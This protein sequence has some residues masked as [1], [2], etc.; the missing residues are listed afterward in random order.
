MPELPEVETVRRGLEPYLVG[1]RIVSVELRRPD[2]RFP[3]PPDFAENLTGATVTAAERR[4]KYLLFRLSSG[5][6]WLSHLGMTGSYRFA[7]FV[8]KSASRYYEPTA[9]EKHDHIQ[10]QLSHPDHGEMLLIYNDARRFGFMDLFEDEATSPYLKDLGPEPLSNSFSAQSM[11]QRFRGR[12][13]PM[14]AV[15]LDQ[16]VV[17]GLGNIY[18]SEAL[19]RAHIRP[20]RAA[21]SLVQPDGAA[22]PALDRLAAAVR[23]VLNEAIAAGGSTLRDFRNA[24]GGAGY[25]QHSFSVYDRE[26]EPCPTPGCDGTITRIV[27]SGRS[28]FFCPRC[29]H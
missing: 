18:V 10:L 24:E 1:A 25:F 2:L 17:A 3:L 4:A 20:A 29:Q 7:D 26:G 27:Q 13:A 6:T 19:H 15:L 28:S 8:Y 23:D 11:A 5:P 21:G 16:R 14:K 12:S 22:D 9:A